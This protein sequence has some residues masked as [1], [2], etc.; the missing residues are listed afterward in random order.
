M[1]LSKM[2]G[3]DSSEDGQWS[4]DGKLRVVIKTRDSVL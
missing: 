4:A 2:L 1:N 3:T